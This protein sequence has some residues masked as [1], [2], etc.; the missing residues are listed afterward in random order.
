MLSEQNGLTQA[1]MAEIKELFHDCY[2]F[3]PFIK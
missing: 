2:M 3:I 1:S